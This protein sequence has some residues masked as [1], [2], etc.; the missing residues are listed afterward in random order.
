[1]VLTYWRAP[2]PPQATGSEG[3]YPAPGGQ[4]GR[5]V[6][7]A[8]GNGNRTRVPPLPELERYRPRHQGRTEREIED[9]T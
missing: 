8:G 1:M 3:A 5:T 9:A 2:S 4:A 7:R 6:R